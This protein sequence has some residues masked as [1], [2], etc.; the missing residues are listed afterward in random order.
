MRNAH[1]F[2]QLTQELLVFFFFVIQKKKKRKNNIFLFS[3]LHEHSFVLPHHKSP[4]YIFRKKIHPVP[5]L[6]I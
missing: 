6:F 4:I 3:L 2:V 1:K 5:I